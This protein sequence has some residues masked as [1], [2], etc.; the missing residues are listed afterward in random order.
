M[1]KRPYTLLLA[2]TLILSSFTPKTEDKVSV[3]VAANMQF[4]MQQLK[5]EFE[6]ETA[7]QVDVTV[8][9]SGKLCAQIIESAPF[10]VFVSADMSYAEEL[11][12][13]GFAANAPEVYA[14]G[15]LVLWTMDNKI[16][17]TADLKV[18]YTPGVKKIAIANPKTAPYGVA[19]EEALKYYKIYDLVKDKLVYGEN[20]GQTQQFIASQAAEIGFIAK[21]LVLSDEM[22][23]KGKWV[24]ID[25][26]TYAPIA[27]GAVVLKH[28]RETNNTPSQKFYQFLY[29]PKAKAI[30]KKYGYIV[31]EK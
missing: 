4:T 8:G 21:S 29:S 31:N 18:L 19:A 6:K 17:P 24:D 25:K 5:A 11:N 14:W 26:K 12:K 10:D 3:A 20:I 23:G 9:S 2:L 22:K 28:G 30:F 1:M 13:K 7:I 15:S 27:Q 16:T